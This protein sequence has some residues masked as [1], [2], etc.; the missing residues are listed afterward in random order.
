MNPEHLPRAVPKLKAPAL[1]R[2]EDLFEATKHFGFD[3]VGISEQFLIDAEAAWHAKRDKDGLAM[4]EFDREACL[5]RTKP[6]P[7]RQLAW[8][9]R[10]GGGWGG[11]W[12]RV[13]A[14][15]ILKA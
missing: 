11:G 15:A 10:G 12:H 5:N 3:V 6:P 7:I 2:T 1:H 13:Q 14:V 8:S 9:V 4:A